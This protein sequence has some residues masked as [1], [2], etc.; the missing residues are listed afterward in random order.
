MNTRV[1]RK[2]LISLA[3]A[4]FEQAGKN[5]NYR[6]KWI[7]SSSWL[8]IIQESHLGGELMAKM[9]A[10]Q[11]TRLIKTQYLVTD[12]NNLNIYGVYMREKRIR[13]GRGRSSQKRITCFLVTEPNCLPSEDESQWYY[14]ITD[15]PP[16]S[17]PS[18]CPHETSPAS[19]PHATSPASHPPALSPA[20]CP[21]ANSHANT[22]ASSPDSCTQ[23]TTISPESSSSTNS[24][25]SQPSSLLQASMPDQHHNNIPIHLRSYFHSKEARNVFG[26]SKPKSEEEAN[27]DVRD[28]IYE[29][30]LQFQKGAFTYSGWRDLMEHAD[31]K[32]KCDVRFINAIQMKAKY[33]F[34]A[35]SILIDKKENEP[36]TWHRIC[37][38][39]IEKVMKFEGAELIKDQEENGEYNAYHWIKPRTIMKWFRYFRDNGESF[40]NTPHR[41]SLIEKTPA[42]F[43]LNPDLKQRFISYAKTNITGL[44][45]KVMYDFIHHTI[46]PELIENEKK[47]TG[48]SLTKKEILKC[49]SLTTLSMDTVYSWMRSFGFKYSPSKKTYYVD[50]HEKPETVKYRKEYVSKYLEDELRCF[51]WVQLT[52]EEVEKIEKEN[53]KFDRNIGFKYKDPM[54]NL[55]MFEYHVDDIQN[56]HPKIDSLPFG[57][58]LSF[59]KKEEDKPII[60]IGQDECIFKQFLLVKKQWYLP[61]GTTSVNPKGEGMGIMLSSFCSWETLATV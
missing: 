54:S 51:R 58:S 50:G 10:R 42:L 15:V 27:R 13:S 30:M 55:T 26:Y 17:S 8:K 47:E 49:Y 1:E 48:E 29:R 35:F 36:L 11:F 2:G 52:I 40:I 46:V 33:L 19:H 25:F 45:A 4:S 59:R 53:E 14:F 12:N 5:Q 6:G 39:A 21:H 23:Q 31:K 37:E 28:I 61:D 7:D 56:S 38:L 3:K 20:T 57:D 18:L 41:A 44:T 32:N 60:M 9:K 24:A 16:H 22:Q 43:Q 34:H